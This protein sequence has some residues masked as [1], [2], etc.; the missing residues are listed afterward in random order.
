MVINVKTEHSKATQTKPSPKAKG[1]FCSYHNNN[2]Y[3]GISLA[4]KNPVEEKRFLPGVRLY[5]VNANSSQVARKDQH[6]RPKTKVEGEA[7]RIDL[8]IDLFKWFSTE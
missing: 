5:R 3:Y 8:W 4:K 2:D 7:E 6:L 1:G